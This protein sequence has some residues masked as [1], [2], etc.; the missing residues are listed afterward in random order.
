MKRITGAGKLETKRDYEI[1]LKLNE[2]S[3]SKEVL[4]KFHV[5]ETELSDKLLGYDII[6][7]LDI[8]TELSII[9]NYKE[10]TVEWE[11]AKIAMTTDKTNLNRKQ[12]QV[13]LLSTQEPIS[14]TS[15]K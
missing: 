6:M 9:S 14:T 11:E 8:M 3:T 1:K 13:V 15:E 4:W 10:Q 12:L 7:G 5:D 2:F